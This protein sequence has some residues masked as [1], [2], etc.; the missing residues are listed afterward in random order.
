MLAALRQAGLPPAQFEDRI[1]T[2]RVTFQMALN[3]TRHDRR[4]VIVSLLQEHGELSRAQ[5]AQHLRLTD[6]AVRKW[7]AILRNER[8]IVPTELKSRSKNVRYRL[9]RG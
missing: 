5:L 4:D 9:A 8:I 6:I 3:R 7:L 2:F 1:A